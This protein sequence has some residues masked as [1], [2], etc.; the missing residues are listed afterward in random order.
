MLATGMSCTFGSCFFG[1]D[2][3]NDQLYLLLLFPAGCAAASVPAAG[4]AAATAALLSALLHTS[5]WLTLTVLLKCLLLILQLAGTCGLTTTE[6]P[7][8]P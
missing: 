5:K 3:S 4:C 7:A 1:A 8:V 2:R 6:R